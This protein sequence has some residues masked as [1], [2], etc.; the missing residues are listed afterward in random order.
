MV[1]MR[2]RVETMDHRD[3]ALHESPRP[4]SSPETFLAS[5]LHQLL[6]NLSDLVVVIDARGTIQF[7][8]RD[9]AG[10]N[11]EEAVGT[12]VSTLLAPE[13]RRAGLRT[14]Q[15]HQRWRR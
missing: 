2:E 6:D 1:S 7:A 4:R 14:R 9:F 3:S 8:S 13:H 12:P 11:V 5:R 15:G 10:L